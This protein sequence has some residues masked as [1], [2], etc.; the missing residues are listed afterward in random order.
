MHSSISHNFEREQLNQGL[1]GAGYKAR[2]RKIPA[3]SIDSEKMRE[4]LK[5]VNE[6]D[7][8]KWRQ[9]WA[10]GIIYGCAL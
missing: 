4:L 3:G 1:Q 7:G 8:S 9:K 10:L 6:S 2:V 5:Y